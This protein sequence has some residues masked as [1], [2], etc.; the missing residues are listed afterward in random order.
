M[1]VFKKFG[2]TIKIRNDHWKRLRARYN[3]ENATLNTKK[4]YYE[5]KRMCPF[6]N[7]YNDECDGCPFEEFGGEYGCLEFFERLFRGG[8]RFDHGLIDIVTWD[9][10][11]DKEARKQLNRLQ[12]MMDKIEA[13]QGRKD[14]TK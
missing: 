2:E 9:E 13:S 4:G 6:C 12:A 14:G 8:T 7:V 3:P 1:I 5:I 11:E 10:Y